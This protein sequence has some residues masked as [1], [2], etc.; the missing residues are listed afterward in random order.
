MR[1]LVLVSLFIVFAAYCNGQHRNSP[2]DEKRI[3]LLEECWCPRQTFN[4]DSI[5]S[6]FQS[7]PIFKKGYVSFEVEDEPMPCDTVI[8]EIEK[9]Y[10][11][12]SLYRYYM[13]DNEII[14]SKTLK[15]MLSAIMDSTTQYTVPIKKWNCA[16]LGEDWLTKSNKQYYDI[17][18]DKRMMESNKKKYENFMWTYGEANSPIRIKMS[19]P[20]FD[21]DYRYAFMVFRMYG[22][23]Y[24]NFALFERKE[25]GWKPIL[26][27]KCK[28]TGRIDKDFS[29]CEKIMR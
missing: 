17:L 8:M 26:V 18:L 5:Y 29:P 21:E 28:R 7:S 25:E 16:E 23:S 24:A 13:E 20:V 22:E 27:S 12:F 3:R 6:F 1:R 11:L 10:M 2:E 19:I 14:P 9:Q 4:T 15:K